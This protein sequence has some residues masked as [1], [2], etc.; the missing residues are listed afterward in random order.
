MD[1]AQNPSAPAGTR[2]RPPCS[3]QNRLHVPDYL[4]RSGLTT[5]RPAMI[6]SVEV[7]GVQLSGCRC[8][9][10]TNCRRFDPSPAGS[11]RLPISRSRWSRTSPTRRP[12]PS[13]TRGC[14]TNCARTATSRSLASRPR[15]PDVLRVISRSPIDLQPVFDASLVTAHAGS[16]KRF[17]C[18]CLRR[19]RLPL[20]PSRPWP[21][22]ELD[23]DVQRPGI[24]DSDPSVNPRRASSTEKML[25]VPNWDAQSTSRVTSRRT[26][27]TFRREH[28]AVLAAA[29]RRRAASAL[30]HAGGKRPTFRRQQIELVQNL[31]RPGRHRHRKCAAVQAERSAPTN[32]PNRWS[33]RRPRP[34]CSRVISS[35]A[36]RFASRFSMPCW[37]TAARLVRGP[38]RQSVSFK[39]SGAV[40]AGALHNDAAG[41]R[42]P[43]GRAALFRAGSTARHVARCGREGSRSTSRPC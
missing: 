18:S 34:K 26:S 25:H 40:R 11:G 23:R 12:S 15:R 10:T 8:S 31:R 20:S 9:K 30:H 24:V 13:R 6:S 33:S 36:R 14:S 29:A 22:P 35:L 2:H 21:P 38:I 5:S 28:G 16:A 43:F 7:G 32:S 37:R 19:R 17:R 1:S 41:L 39:K 27:A 3:Q 42:R 4:A